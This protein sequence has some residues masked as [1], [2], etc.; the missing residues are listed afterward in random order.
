MLN[1]SYLQKAYLE[2]TTV[3]YTTI[4]EEENPLCITRVL[5]PPLPAETDRIK[6]RNPSTTVAGKPLK[7]QTAT[8][9]IQI[10]TKVSC[11]FLQ[12]EYT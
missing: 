11:S 8:T 5:R 12:N 1:N 10:Y 6:V 4:T 9:R 7:I 2:R 3:P